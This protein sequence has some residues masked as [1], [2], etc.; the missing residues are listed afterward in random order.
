MPRSAVMSRIFNS[1]LLFA[2]VTLCH[3][4]THARTIY[5][6]GVITPPLH[7]ISGPHYNNAESGIIYS[8]DCFGQPD[9]SADDGYS[10]CLGMLGNGRHVPEQFGAFS[11]EK[12]V[13]VAKQKRNKRHLP[14][15]LPQGQEVIAISDP[16]LAANGRSIYNEL[17]A[18]SKEQ[19]WTNREMSGIAR[20]RDGSLLHTCARDWYNVGK[21]IFPT[22][23]LTTFTNDKASAKGPFSFRCPAG[24]KDLCH[25]EMVGAYVG[26]ISNQSFAD[27]VFAKSGFSKPGEEIC[28]TGDLRA[29]GAKA[30]RSQGTGLYA[31]RCAD[32]TRIDKGV[33]DA[34]PIMHHPHNPNAFNDNWNANLIKW[35][36]YSSKYKW[37]PTNRCYDIAWG[38]FP[39][40]DSTTE[41]E[42]D[43]GM[44]VACEFGGPVWWYGKADPWDDPNAYR[45]RGQNG[46]DQCLFNEDRPQTKAGVDCGE[47][48]RSLGDPIPKGFT[49]PCSIY[50]GYHGV[51]AEAPYRRAILL[52]YRA[53]DLAASA[54]ASMNGQDREHLSNVPFDVVLDMPA[55][56]WE[57]DCGGFK[58]VAFDPATKR[59]FIQERS[60][61]SPLI[62]V[63][64]M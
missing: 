8:P 60:L 50:K 56:V 45:G 57:R 3:S 41:G 1:L 35:P 22:H 16:S 19:G 32:M 29:H 18:K 53:D 20:L 9:P 63:F 26:S 43:D 31:F 44:F 10:G 25:T 59:L 51:A 27:R 36:Q 64:S 55:Q 61:Y 7:D 13:T 24:Y 52:F 58:G 2:L 6:H 14:K 54:L 30:T 46:K 5:Y 49:N 40:K 48:F 21:K 47:I 17:T 4:V 15:S 23:C 33:I 42:Y 39:V 11:I 12:P 37:S 38:Q 28:L 62:H 34:L